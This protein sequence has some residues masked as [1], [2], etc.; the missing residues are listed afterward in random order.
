MQQSAAIDRFCHPPEPNHECQM[1]TN[2]GRTATRVENFGRSAG[3]RKFRKNCSKQGRKIGHAVDVSKKQNIGSL[4]RPPGRGQRTE[5]SS[6]GRQKGELF[7][8][9]NKETGAHEFEQPCKLTS[10][11]YAQ[12]TTNTRISPKNTR[13]T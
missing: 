9:T 3:G 13:L 11:W 12:T 1:P 2:C 5:P 4:V 10:L 8:I 7:P 6:T